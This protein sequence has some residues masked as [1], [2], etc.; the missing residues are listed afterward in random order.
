[1]KI[2]CY[3]SLRCGSEDALRENISKALEL[4]DISADVNFYRI[5]DEKAKNLGLRGS[6]SV[7]INGKDIQPVDITGFS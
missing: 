7:L 5:T 1:M 2:D 3:M 4:E 6:P